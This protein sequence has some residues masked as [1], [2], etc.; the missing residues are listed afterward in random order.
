MTVYPPYTRRKSMTAKRY[1]F[2]LRVNFDEEHKQEKEEMLMLAAARMAKGLMSIAMLISDKSPPKLNM[3]MSDNMNG[4]EEVNLN[5]INTD[6]PCPTC[7]H[8]A[9]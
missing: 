9:T 8:D 1:F 7:G 3:V 5:E 6:G 2:E 4:D